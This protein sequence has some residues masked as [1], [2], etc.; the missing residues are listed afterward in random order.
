MSVCP[1]L[2]RS[3]RFIEQGVA[4]PCSNQP[5]ALCSVAFHNGDFFRGQF[6]E[7]INQFVDLLVGRVNSALNKGLF[8]GRFWLPTVACA[9]IEQ[10]VA[11]PYSMFSCPSTMAI[12]S[13]VSPYNS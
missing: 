12:S 4:T 10:G 1:F 7:F 13:G 3:I 2:L 11:T 6:I 9:M 8:H 5:L